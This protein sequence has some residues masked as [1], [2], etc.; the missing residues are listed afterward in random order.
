MADVTTILRDLIG[1][2][3]SDMARQK[4]VSSDL[5]PEVHLERPKRED[6]GD[7]ATNVAMQAC[8]LL[9]E[10]P[11]NLAAMVVD[12]LK[13]DEHIRSVE[14]AGP[15]FINFFLADR[16]IGNVISSVLSSGDD[17]GR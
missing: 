8:K 1:E 7:W 3:L 4:E 10:N 15:G 13:D 5:L 17:Y 16:W 12:R 6:Q 11:R 2:A 9:G 14:V